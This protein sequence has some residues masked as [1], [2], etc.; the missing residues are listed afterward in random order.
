MSHQLMEPRHF[1]SG[2]MLSISQNVCLC[3]CLFVRLFT[4]EVPFKGLFAPTSWSQMSKVFRIVESLGKSN[5]KKWSQ[6]WNFLLI[7][8]VKSLHKKNCSWANFATL[9]KIFLVLVFLTSFNSLLFCKF[10]LT[11]RIFWYWCYYPHRSKDALSP[12]CGI[13]LIFLADTV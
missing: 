8:G 6:I 10:C 3:F 13:F 11:S 5:G 7:K 2:P 9:S 1:P 12:V 4:F